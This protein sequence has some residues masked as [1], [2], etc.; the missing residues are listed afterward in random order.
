MLEWSQ[1]E[2]TKCAAHPLGSVRLS[3]SVLIVALMLMRMAK[4]GPV[5][6]PPSSVRPVGMLLVMAAAEPV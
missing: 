4:P 3:E 6:I 1:E 2:R 5:P